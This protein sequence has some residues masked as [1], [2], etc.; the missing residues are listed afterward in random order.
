MAT[1]YEPITSEETIGSVS[2]LSAKLA[3]F[4]KAALTSSTVGCLVN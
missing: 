1:E 4:S 2:Y 3:D